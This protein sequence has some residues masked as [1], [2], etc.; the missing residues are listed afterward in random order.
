MAVLL[1]E[2]ADKGGM[3]IRLHFE[4]GGQTVSV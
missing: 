1:D 2:V 3:N 4:T